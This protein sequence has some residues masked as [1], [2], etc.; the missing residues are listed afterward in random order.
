VSIDS[1]LRGFL[2]S[3][4]ERLEASDRMASMIDGSQVW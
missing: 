3:A 1:C 2:P 4:F